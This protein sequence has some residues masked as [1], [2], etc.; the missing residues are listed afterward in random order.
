MT[1]CLKCSTCLEFLDKNGSLF[2]SQYGFRP[3]MSCEHALLN[4][5][6][7]ILDSLSKKQIAVLLLLDYSK[8]FDLIDH[9]IMLKKLNYYG[10]RGIV[11]DWF[12]SYL[13]SRQQFVTVNGVDSSP[14]EIEY[15]IPQGSIL[16]PLLFVIY[17]NDLPGISNL[18]KFILYADDANIIVTG[19]TEEEVQLKLSQI[20]STLVSWVDGNGLALNLKKTHY[21]VFSNQRLDYSKISLNIAGVN[22]ERVTEARFLGVIL[23]LDEKLT[24]QKHITAMKIKMSRYMGVMYKL[25]RFLPIKVRLQ[26]YHSFVQSHLNYCCLTWGFAAKTYIESLFTKPKQGIRMVMPGFVN[27]FYEDGQLPT[28][29]KNAFCD[30]EILTIHGLIVKH[31]LTMMHRIKY[32]QSTVPRSIINLFPDNM[33]NHTSNLNHDNSSEWLNTYSKRGFRSSIF[34]KGPLLTL[35]NTNKQITSLPSLFFFKYIQ[36]ERKTCIARRTNDRWP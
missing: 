17:I 4:A 6:H 10:I 2:E 22:I 19:E 35:T 7:T 12:S 34:F 8:A 5:Q 29:T 15:G 33:P 36:K 30:L 25:K 3:G 9:R 24:W 26:L 13:R 28:H 27:Y 16:G 18:A 11:L 1:Q 21:M 20:A 14:K 32:F 31:A 23:I